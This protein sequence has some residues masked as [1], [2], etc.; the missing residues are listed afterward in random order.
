MKYQIMMVE[1][2]KEIRDIVIKYLEKE[3]YEVLVA[4]DGL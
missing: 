2:Q 4:E 1:D 3:D